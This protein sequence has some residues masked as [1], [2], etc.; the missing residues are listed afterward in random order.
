LTTA[1]CASVSDAIS[2]KRR[3]TSGLRVG[4]E[5]GE[6]RISERE[7]LIAARCYR[8]VK[9]DKKKLRQETYLDGTVLEDKTSCEHDL[10]VCSS[11]VEI[12]GRAMVNGIVRNMTAMELHGHDDEFLN[13]ICVRGKMLRQKGRFIWLMVVEISGGSSGQYMSRP[14]WIDKGGCVGIHRSGEGMRRK[15][16]TDQSFSKRRQYIIAFCLTSMEKHFIP[17]PW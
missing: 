12:V 16:I 8:G 13:C 14:T 17:S 2:S 7:T 10:L 11:D 1:I 15:G 6:S 4:L 9:R 5:K 3:R